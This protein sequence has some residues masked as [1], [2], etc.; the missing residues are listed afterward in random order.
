MRRYIEHIKAKEPHERRASAM[1][2]ALLC[3]AG[4]FF[5]WITTLGV[6]LTAHMPHTTEGESAAQLANVV[7]GTYAPPNYLEV[8]STTDYGGR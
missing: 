6:R 2:W 3:T 8:A 7:S 5:V 1:R 4:L